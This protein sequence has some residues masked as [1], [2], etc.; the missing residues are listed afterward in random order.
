M[1]V[2]VASCIEPS[3][4]TTIIIVCFLVSYDFSGSVTQAVC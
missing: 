4:S 3:S 2:F 1:V